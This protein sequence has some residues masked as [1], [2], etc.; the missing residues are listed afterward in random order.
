VKVRPDE[1][2]FKAMEG[3]VDAVKFLGHWLEDVEDGVPPLES[4]KNALKKSKGPTAKKV[5]KRL[6]KFVTDID[7]E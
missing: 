4:A 7:S 6:K 2:A 3:F 1:I 5:K